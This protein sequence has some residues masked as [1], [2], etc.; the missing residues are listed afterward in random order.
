MM[1][2]LR[3][4]EHALITQAAELS[5]ERWTAS[6]ARKVLLAAA[7]KAAKKTRRASAA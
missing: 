1:L 5:G 3:P 4:S 7:T 6:W 2:R